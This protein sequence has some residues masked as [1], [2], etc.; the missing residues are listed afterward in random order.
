LGDPK[1][2]EKLPPAQF[3]ASFM[4]LGSARGFMLAVPK[5]NVPHSLRGAGCEGR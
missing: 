3:S 2:I 4:L 5:V 1:L